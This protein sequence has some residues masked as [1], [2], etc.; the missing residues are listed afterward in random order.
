MNGKGDKPRNMG[1]KFHKNFKKIKG[2]GRRK[3]GRTKGH[4]VK[5]RKVYK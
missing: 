5:W 4:L 1:P 2:F 3:A